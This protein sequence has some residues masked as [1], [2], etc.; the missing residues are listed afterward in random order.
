[1][2]LPMLISRIAILLGLLITLSACAVRDVGPPWPDGIPPRGS[3]IAE[4]QAS[5]DNRMLQSE[6]EYLEWV[7][8]FYDGYTNVPGWLD[9]T[10]QVLERLPAA[11]RERVGARLSEL[12][13]R[14]G[15]E[16]AKDNA[17]RLLDTRAGAAWRDALLEA[18]ARNELD[19][20]LDKLTTDVDA[21]LAGTLDK[22]AIR[23]E[24]YYVDEFDC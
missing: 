9:I 1:M 5:G 8:R 20:Y 4:W 6:E 7:L 15:G 21:L 16:W 22:S 19:E 24:R 3:F 23:F 14:I 18:L 12:G 2:S 17:V 10:Q 11:D 13:A